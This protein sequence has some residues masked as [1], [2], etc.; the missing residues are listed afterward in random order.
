M[1]ANPPRPRDRRRWGARALALSL[2]IASTAAVTM[3]AGA[4]SANAATAAPSFESGAVTV[5]GLNRTF[6][7]FI[8][9]ARRAPKTSTTGPAPLVVALSSYTHTAADLAGATSLNAAADKAGMYVVYPDAYR[10]RW[11]A[12]LCCALGND[13]TKPPPDDVSYLDAVIAA[14]QAK[15][16]VD[17]TRIY[18]LGLSN[19]AMMA[20]RYACERSRVVAAVI[21]VA[22]TLEVACTADRPVSI[23][24]VS[25]LRDA[26]VPY[27]GSAFS[28]ALGGPLTPVPTAM[29]FWEST[30]RCSGLPKITSTAKVVTRSYEGCASGT[31]VKTITMPLTGHVWP[32]LKT[33]G[34]D[35]TA[36]AMSFM[37]SH[38]QQPTKL[39]AAKLA[40][41]MSAKRIVTEAGNYIAGSLGGRFDLVAGV[42]IQ[43][44][45]RSGTT[46]TQLESEF[47]D[48]KGDF[49]LSEPQGYGE[50]WLSAKTPGLPAVSTSIAL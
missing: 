18:M 26:N 45:G 34:Y 8:P 37:L 30:A 16:S 1:P 48:V 46:W 43:V 7:T 27:M 23:M 22:G 28:Q 9:T 4:P 5:G 31:G 38:K 32:T 24:Q 17:P 20:Q 47:S 39:T 15:Y 35:A 10:L 3:M 49:S 21:S 29:G 13:P 12:G 6:S 40:L 44:W 19:G 42:T 33:D 25:G 14:A 41:T 36:E 2:T 50:I 11:N